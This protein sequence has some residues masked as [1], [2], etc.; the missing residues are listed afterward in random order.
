MIPR[1][2]ETGNMP[3]PALKIADLERVAHHLRGDVIRMTCEAG[4][5]H[6]GGS[7]GAADL[8][9]VLYF[10]TMRIDPK[11]P[12]WVDRDRFILSKGHACPILYAALARRGYFPVEHLMTLRKIDSILQGHP[13]MLKTPGVDMTTGSLGNGLAVG[14]G[15]ALGARMDNAPYRIYVMLGEGDLQE[16]CNWEAAMMAGH[17][18]LSKLTAILDYNRAQVDGLVE[19]IVDPDP[20]ADKWR[21]FNWTVL[22]IDGHHIPQI[23]GALDRA[24]QENQRPTLILARTIKGK[25]VSFMEKDPVYWHGTAPTR[26]QASKALQE[27]GLEAER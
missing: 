2:V 5:G 6:P 15:M 26:Q 16:G 23:I 10:H 4:S 8:M 25:G 1:G 13:D 18:R 22:E 7:L 9:A 21:A 20:V 19:E 17:H 24:Q 12:A 14:V 3:E 27:L 11:N